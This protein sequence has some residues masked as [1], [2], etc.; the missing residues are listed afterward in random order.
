MKRSEANRHKPLWHQVLFNSEMV[1]AILEGKKVQTR[2]PVVKPKRHANIAVYPVR[3]A[4]D[5][6]WAKEGWCIGELAACPFGDN[7]HRLWV[8]ETCRAEELY[9]G[10]D[11]VR[12]RADDTFL[13]IENSPGASDAWCDLY[14]Y[15]KRQHDVLGIGPWVPSIHAPKWTSRLTLRVLELRVE[16][17][18][19]I[20]PKDAMAEGISTEYELMSLPAS[21]DK[22][23]IEDPILRNEVTVY[24]FS[25]RWDAIYEDKGLGW[26]ANPWVWVCRFEIDKENSRL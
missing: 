13:P 18:Q 20:T 1:R 2:R 5:F 9:D 15:G 16:R 4:G 7:Y 11:G 8:R 17:V 24:G 14:A 10:Q 6:W 12:Y 19:H 25:S 22:E 23:D 3:V 21:L 26:D